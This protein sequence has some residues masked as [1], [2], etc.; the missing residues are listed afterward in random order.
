MLNLLRQEIWG[1]GIILQHLL[2]RKAQLPECI[3]RLHNNKHKDLL[4]YVSNLYYLDY[5][6]YFS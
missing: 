6:D 3:E 2:T 1:L 5:L 4:S